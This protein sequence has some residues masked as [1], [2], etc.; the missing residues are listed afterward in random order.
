MTADPLQLLRHLEPAVAPGYAVSRARPPRP[1]LEGQRFGD[2]LRLVCRGEL[3]SDRPVVV[4]F[5]ASPPVSAEQHDRLAAA[6]DLAQGHG[7]AAALLLIDGRG[8]LLDV[9][10]RA[11]TAE[12][13][14][15]SSPRIVDVD[16]VVEVESGPPVASSPPTRDEPDSRDP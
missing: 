11:L 15:G 1:P 12:L 2:L 10:R 9:D 8:L 5:Q 4:T 13:A 14:G 3:R 6:T 16:A 7:A